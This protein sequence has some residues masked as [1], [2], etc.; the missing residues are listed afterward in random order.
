M[1]RDHAAIF[2]CA[3]RV[4]QTMNC[5]VLGNGPCRVAFSDEMVYDWKIG[6]NIPWT[7]CDATVVIDSGVV[8]VWAKNPS[9]IT[10]PTYFSKHA[11]MRV[12]ERKCR[13]QFA[14][15]FAEIIPLSHPYQS[16]GHCAAQV[17][18]AK[19][20]DRIDVFGADAMFSTELASY[21]HDFLNAH[22]D[23]KQVEGW[24]DRWKAIHDAH[25]EVDLRFIHTSYNGVIKDWRPAC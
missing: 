17:A 11:W 24:R 21:T 10:C 20:Y 19:G 13:E 2:W 25:P 9:L 6:C 1:A 8:D 14:S 22:F 18:I 4:C 15:Q 3:H 5:A 12:A 16:S 7:T 23:I